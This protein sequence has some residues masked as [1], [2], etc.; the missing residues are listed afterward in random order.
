MMVISWGYF[1]I[2]IYPDWLIYK[3]EFIKRNELQ[4]YTS[5]KIIPRFTILVVLVNNNWASEIATPVSL[6]N[7]VIH[8][9]N[10]RQRS[11]Y[12]HFYD[13]NPLV[14]GEMVQ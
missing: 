6:A 10:D 2:E 5:L 7:F 14:M 9:K 8:S 3:K 4:V 11:R 13:W 12:V 1:I